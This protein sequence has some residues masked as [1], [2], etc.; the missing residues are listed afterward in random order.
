VSYRARVEFAVL[1]GTPVVSALLWA[2]PGRRRKR[3][4]GE[5]APVALERPVL[6]DH[7]T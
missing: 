1:T 5:P 7:S 6:A 3:P 4:A 2:L